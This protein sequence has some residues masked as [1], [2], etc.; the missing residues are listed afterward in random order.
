[1]KRLLSIGLL[2]LAGGILGSHLQANPGNPGGVAKRVAQGLVVDPVSEPYRS[3]TGVVFRGVESGP[4]KLRFITDRRTYPQPKKSAKDS[5]RI[6]S[7]GS[8]G[9]RSQESRV[10]RLFR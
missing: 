5:D 3:S 1:M 6:E 8:L 7:R 2:L 9:T 4:V 10:R